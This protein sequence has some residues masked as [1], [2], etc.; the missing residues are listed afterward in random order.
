[1]DWGGS[2]AVRALRQAQ[3]VSV[4][5]H[6]AIITGYLV[7]VGQHLAGGPCLGGSSEA[8]CYG[9]G[10]RYHCEKLCA[11]VADFLFPLPSIRRGR[12]ERIPRPGVPQ[13]LAASVPAWYSR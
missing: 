6:S 8:E 12:M 5:F 4:P 2:A 1:M 9:S 11:H 3:A 10:C 13:C 7:A